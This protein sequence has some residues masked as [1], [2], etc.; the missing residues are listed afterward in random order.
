MFR[1]I[2][3]F[4]LPSFH[5]SKRHVL[6]VNQGPSAHAGERQCV[7]CGGWYPENE[8][9]QNKYSGDWYHEHHP[10]VSYGRFYPN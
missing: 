6:L 3:A 8:M 7:H 2:K 10:I 1:W 5:T 9:V 4:L